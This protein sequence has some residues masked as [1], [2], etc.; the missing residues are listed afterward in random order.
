M[1][2]NKV[3]KEETINVYLSKETT[4]IAF[5]NKL[6]ELI[7]CGMSEE[8]ATKFIET[9]PFCLELYYE[10]GCGLFAVES[11]ALEFCEIH[12][13]YTKELMEENETNDEDVTPYIIG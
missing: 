1:K 8:E 4:P 5:Q 3:G 13:P 10:K 12:S 11:E 9:T 7:E 6:E 2:I